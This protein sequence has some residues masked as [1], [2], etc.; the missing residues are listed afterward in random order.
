[1]TESPKEYMLLSF[2]SLFFVNCGFVPLGE[3]HTQVKHFSRLKSL[4]AKQIRVL[5]MLGVRVSV[6]YQKCS[7]QV[8]TI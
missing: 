6:R 4:S 2:S 5:S 3:S 1:M 7:S 8:A